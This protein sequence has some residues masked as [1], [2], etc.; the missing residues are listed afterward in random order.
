VHADYKET[1]PALA[2]EKFSVERNAGSADTIKYELQVAANNTFNS[3][4]LDDT[5]LTDTTRTVN[6]LLKPKT[7]YFWRVQARTS[8]QK[9]GWSAVCSRD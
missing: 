1:S 8:V 9:S 4:T 2:T 6:Y 3:T 5:L 7:T